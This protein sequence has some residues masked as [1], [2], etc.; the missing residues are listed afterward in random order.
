MKSVKPCQRSL[1]S[2]RE[3][4]TSESTRIFKGRERP[5]KNGHSSVLPEMKDWKENPMRATLKQN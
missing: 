5:L 4:T 3:G 2:D 1:R